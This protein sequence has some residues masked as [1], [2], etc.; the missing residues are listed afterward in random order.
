[1]AADVP[2]ALILHGLGG[3]HRYAFE[4]FALQDT[5][6]K[7]AGATPSQP[8][9]LAAIDGGGGYW[10]PR[11]SGDDPQGML[12]DEF[13]PLLHGM[14]I[15]THDVTALG[16]SMGGYGSLL[17]A[18]SYPTLLRRVAVMSPAIW[19]TYA[20]SHNANPDA[21]DSAADWHAHSVIARLRSLTGT[22]V[23]VACGLSDPFLPASR[24][25]S[26]LL[27]AGD[28]L[29]VPGGHNDSFWTAHAP[30]MLAFLAAR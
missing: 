26:T 7:L 12:V 8:I 25:L 19:P 11:A 10:H 14:G 13:L 24:Q 2:V 3:D 9:V 18:E 17:L 21:F 29:L 15:A 6:A 22:P 28:V 27:A 5:Q 1:V 30:G 16:W 4:H 20:D 23:R